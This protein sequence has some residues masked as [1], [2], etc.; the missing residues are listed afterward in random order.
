[1]SKYINLGENNGRLKSNHQRRV[2]IEWL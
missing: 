2:G 1:V